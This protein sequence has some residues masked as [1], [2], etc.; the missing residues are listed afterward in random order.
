MKE[1][2][3]IFKRSSDDE[4]LARCLKGLTQNQN[5][6]VTAQLWS[7]CPKITFTGPRRVQIAVCETVSVFNTGSASKAKIM[8][9]C[10]V[11]P[12]ANMLKAL[13]KEDEVRVKSA[14]QKISQKYVKQRKLLRAK[15]KAKGDNSYS[16]GAFGLSSMPEISLKKERK[17]KNT[18]NKRELP[19]TSQLNLNIQET[20]EITFVNPDVEVDAGSNNIN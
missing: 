11:S 12:G 1:L 19:S 9:L 8:G 13:R 3:P 10:G 16:F 15:K 18:N 4:L 20:C 2:D 17:S 6:S 14:A 5:E 7:R